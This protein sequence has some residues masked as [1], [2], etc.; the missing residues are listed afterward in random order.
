MTGAGLP[1]AVFCLE[2]IVLGQCTVLYM[3]RAGLP[4]AVFC[5]EIIVLGQCT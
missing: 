2:I 5:L 4:V 3:T 1:A